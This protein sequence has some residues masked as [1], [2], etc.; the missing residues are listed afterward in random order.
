MPNNYADDHN[1]LMIINPQFITLLIL[2][3][4]DIFILEL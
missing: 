1:Y 4:L 2:R 3:I